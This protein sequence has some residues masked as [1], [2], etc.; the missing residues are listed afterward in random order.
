MQDFKQPE[1]KLQ[2]G[3]GVL[4]AVERLRRRGREL[5]ADLAKISGSPF[6]SVYVRKKIK[7]A[8]LAL[9]QQGQPVVS[10]VIEHDGA[11]IWPTQSVRSRVFAEQPGLAFAAA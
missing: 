9:A 10:N 1:P 3:E 8:V 2:R 4:D 7:E 11:I 5:K 6:P